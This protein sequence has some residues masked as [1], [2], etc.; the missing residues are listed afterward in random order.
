[1][2]YLILAIVLLSSC[3]LAITV[4]STRFFP[5]TRKTIKIAVID[6]GINLKNIN[7][8]ICPNGLI[9]YTGTGIQDTHGHGQN[10]AHIIGS[11]LKGINYC[12]Y[13]IK[14]TVS[15]KTDRNYS[16]ESFRKAR[17]LKVDIINYSAGGDG[18]LEA[19]E[20]VIKDLDRLAIPVITAA[21]NDHTDLSMRC[22]YFPACYIEQNVVVVGSMTDKRE[23][24]SFSNYGPGIINFYWYGE[25]Q[26]YGGYEFSGTSQATAHVTGLLAK[27]WKK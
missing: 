25:N 13:I 24:S 17:D 15:Q 21:G 23:V 3:S 4:D 6:T 1:M 22:T 5:V 20:N 10:I 16:V 2:K 14:F 7:V 18:P 11:H 9:D 12:L 27:G 19:E 8:N 26:D